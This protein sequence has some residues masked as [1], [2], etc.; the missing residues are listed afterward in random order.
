[1]KNKIKNFLLKK[2]FKALRNNKG[3]SLIEIMVVVGIIAVVAGIAIPQ[4]NQYKKTAGYTA[5]D[6]SLTNVARAHNVCIATDTFDNCKSLSQIKITVEGNKNAGGTS[7]KFCADIDS[8]IGG[9]DIKAC[10]A[11][12]S[13]AGTVK[14][15]S[16]RKFCFVDDTTTSCGASCTCAAGYALPSGQAACIETL[17]YAQGPCAATTDCQSG[18]VC[19]S[20]VTATGV[21]NGT[22]GTCG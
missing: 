17:K 9:E 13:S 8:D 15:T 12:D 20:A 5:L 1:M 3:L 10:V 6:A 19:Q 7:P 21:C 4:F 22:A 16:N 18:Q 14:R 2:R 11:V